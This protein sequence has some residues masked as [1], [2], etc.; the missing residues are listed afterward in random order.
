[1]GLSSRGE[2]ADGWMGFEFVRARGRTRGE[3]TVMK[4]M[5]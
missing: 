2:W 3:H 1:M 5:K 4:L